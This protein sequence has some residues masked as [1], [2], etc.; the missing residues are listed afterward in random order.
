MIAEDLLN[1]LEILTQ[2]KS[3]SSKLVLELEFPI[4]EPS[5]PVGRSSAI[6]FVYSGDF[7]NFDLSGS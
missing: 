7:L 2:P 4:H 1:E 6:S 3:I 5:Y